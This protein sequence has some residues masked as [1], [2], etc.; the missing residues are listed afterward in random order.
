MLACWRDAVNTFPLAIRFM[1]QDRRATGRSSSAIRAAGKSRQSGPRSPL[2]AA[3][4]IFHAAKERESM[5]SNRGST[6]SDGSGGGTRNRVGDRGDSVKKVILDL[7]A[8]IARGNTAHA[9]LEADVAHNKSRNGQLSDALASTTAMVSG[10]AQIIPQLQ[11]EIQALQRSVNKKCDIQAER[12]Q[13]IPYQSVDMA[14]ISSQVFARVHKEFNTVVSDV[15]TACIAEQNHRIA[16][17]VQRYIDVLDAKN[18]EARERDA[19]AVN[20]LE[21]RMESIEGKLRAVQTA[22]SDRGLQF[23]R[24]QSAAVQSYRGEMQAV[25]ETMTKKVND[26]IAA[27]TSFASEKPMEIE[28]RVITSVNSSLYSICNKL[29]VRSESCESAIRSLIMRSQTVDNS[30]SDLRHRLFR[31]ESLASHALN[32]VSDQSEHPPRREADCLF[33]QANSPGGVGGI[34]S[35]DGNQSPHST[36]S[37][38]SRLGG[39]VRE[40]LHALEKDQSHALSRLNVLHGE[41]A[42]L[43][44]SIAASH[45]PSDGST[46]DALY[47]SSFDLMQALITRHE[48]DIKES[49]EKLASESRILRG[50][51]SS[52]LAYQADMKKD[53]LVIRDELAEKSSE[54]EMKRMMK[55]L[56]MAALASESPVPSI[57]MSTPEPVVENVPGTPTNVPSGV[58]AAAVA[59]PL[60][61]PVPYLHVSRSISSDSITSNKSPEQSTTAARSV[62]FIP[63]AGKLSSNVV[64]STTSRPTSEVSSPLLLSDVNVIRDELVD[65]LQ[66]I[67]KNMEEKCR[68]IISSELEHQRQRDATHVKT[69]F[70]E[71][72]SVN[73]AGHSLSSF[74]RDTPSKN[75]VSDLVGRVEEAIRRA[76]SENSNGSKR[77]EGDVAR[78]TV[79]P[80]HLSAKKKEHRR[81]FQQDIIQGRAFASNSQS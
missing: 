34:S 69:Q 60:F 14:D 44:E 77:S 79:S 6:A 31:T 63:V 42:A 58:S 67:Q 56:L 3:R 73:S 26:C 30:L 47:H 51:I 16:D 49:T 17:T 18:R 32:V 21:Q 10:F 1:D 50:E 74:V 72:D 23:E 54:K 71:T 13:P 22:V 61:R 20:H 65:A 4:E 46:S 70:S 27:N 43:K 5:D 62:D 76:N 19:A 55:K 37:P 9:R 40:A 75:V 8:S 28:K 80:E 24:I 36:T 33:L 41:V 78:S 7:E 15:V 38:R 57:L 29:E 66:D 68:S 52:C 39:S 53:L 59:S 11:S 81:K 25:L 12:M 48:V 35:D 2:T 64:P 45:K